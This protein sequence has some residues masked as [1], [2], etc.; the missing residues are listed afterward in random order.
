MKT[1]HLQEEAEFNEALGTPGD[2]VTTFR[3][4]PVAYTK[5]SDFKAALRPEPDEVLHRNQWTE[6]P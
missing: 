3:L 1:I 6:R 2:R 5:G 4:T